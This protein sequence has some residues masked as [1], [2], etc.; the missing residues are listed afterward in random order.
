LQFWKLLHFPEHGHELPLLVR[1]Q[2]F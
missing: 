1:N 2:R